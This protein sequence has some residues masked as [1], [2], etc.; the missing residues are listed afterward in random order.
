MFFYEKNAENSGC[1]TPL[2]NWG[3]SYYNEDGLMCLKDE[4]R[5]IVSFRFTEVI[6]TEKSNKISDIQNKTEK[7]TYGN[8][9]FGIPS[10]CTV[11]Q[12]MSGM[13]L[14]FYI[15][16]VAA[17]CVA[18]YA[19]YREATARF[20]PEMTFDKSE[21]PIVYIK[22]RELVVKTRSERHGKP[23]STVGN[24]VLEGMESASVTENGTAVFFTAES[25]NANGGYDLYYG[26]V[27]DLRDEE[28]AEIGKILIDRGV[29]SFKHHPDGNFVLYAK[30]KNLYFSDLSE[31]NVVATDVTEYYL[32]TNYQQIIYYKDD[33]RLY[34]C[35]TDPQD[36]PVLID[37]EIEK[38][39]SG[40]REY[41]K[42]YYLKKGALY[43]REPD[44]ERECL[45]ENV[46]DAVLLGDFV[47]FI[48]E[49][50]RPLLFSDMFIDE[51][52]QTDEKLTAPKLIDF[53]RTAD[54]DKIVDETA[55][56]EARMVYLGKL[57]RDVIR[58]FFQE[59]P[60][61]HRVNVLYTIRR[62]EIRE[63][64][65]GI[66]DDTFR[67]CSSKDVIYYKKTVY[68]RE[69]IRL[70]E[71][72]DL[73]EAQALATSFQEQA[74]Q[75]VTY[76]MYVLVKDKIPFEGT[77]EF[78]DGQV[79]ITPD[80]K[81]LYC[82]ENAGEDGRG[83]LV[84]YTMGTK[85]LKSR[86]ELRTG[87]TD[88]AVDGADS[89]VVMVFDGNKLGICMG[90]T[91]TH[92]SNSSCRSFFYV[93]GTLFFYNEYDFATQSGQLKTFR[94]GKIKRIDYGVHDFDVRNLKTVTYIK[95]FNPEYNVG[96]LYLKDGN[97]KSRRLDFS[98][99]QI[100]H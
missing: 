96:D 75:Q 54:G 14:A 37:S 27:S 36:R 19:G 89:E 50:E 80:Q 20:L 8:E 82:V 15:V 32:S 79:E 29:T 46:K 41:A 63:I 43:L 85:S 74:E 81:Y 39:L 100:L 70:S 35:G 66:A 24:V 49:E 97:K 99:S 33:G 4:H 67:R 61:M 94:D 60:I 45:V 34:T 83:T 77:A 11:K 40:K 71:V 84:R 65:T 56:E 52:V 7:P 42:I 87:V 57:T 76:S 51:Y 58:T 55:Y 88:F 25:D 68:D 28:N 59:S 93:D 17:I 2:D 92:L 47:Y 48:A 78:P 95:R 10:D 64:G 53:T 44:K 31:S 90:D 91:Y 5:P 73:Q 30:G 18:I 21:Q 72:R 23:V 69:R 62:G 22:N 6:V 9:E 12:H 13:K 1:F 16:V 86:T 38:V 3:K 26:T 98:V